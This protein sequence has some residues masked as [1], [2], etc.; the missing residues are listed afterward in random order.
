M[1]KAA[2]QG[3]AAE[4]RTLISRGASVNMVA[5]DSVTPLHEACIRG[6]AE[7]VRLLL[8]AGAQVSSR[9]HCVITLVLIEFSE[10]KPSHCGEKVW[11]LTRS[12]SEME[13]MELIIC[14]KR[15]G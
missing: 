7:C 10:P 13:Q 5:V 6:Q 9:P 2:S 15:C 1:H 3:E 8:D 14:Y 4:L 11:I 12:G